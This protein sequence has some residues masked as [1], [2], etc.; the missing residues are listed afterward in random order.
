MKTF[1]A[2]I[3]TSLFVPTLAEAQHRKAT[4][5][6]F[7][8]QYAGSIGHVSGGLGYD[9]FKGRARAGIHFGTVPRNQGGPLNIFA[10]KFFYPS[11]SLKL[12][13]K[14]SFNPLDIGLIISYHTGENFK[15]S[16]PDYFASRNYYW[17][18]TSMRI[19]A[20]TETSLSIRMQRNRFVRKLTAYLE[21]NTNDLYLVSYF[22]NAGTLKLTEM[23]KAGTGIRFSF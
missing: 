17:W 6:F 7:V 4:P 3:L 8:V 1:Y 22:T 20:A 10:G 11:W 21:L 15:L 18:H 2:I 9:I 5:D 13:E 12:S 16:V 23:I 14:T 19:H